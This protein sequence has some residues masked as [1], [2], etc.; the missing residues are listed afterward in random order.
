MW[1]RVHLLS[2]LGDLLSRYRGLKVNESYSHYEMCTPPVPNVQV[3]PIL[4]ELYRT[5]I[6]DGTIADVQFDRDVSVVHLSLR[7]LQVRHSFKLHNVQCLYPRLS[8]LPISAC[9]QPESS[10]W[11][12]MACRGPGF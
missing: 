2:Y 8:R 12:E 6:P 3:H 1:V 10:H 7:F 4:P 9:F 5:I 11:E